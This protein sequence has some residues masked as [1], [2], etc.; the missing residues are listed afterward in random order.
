MGSRNREGGGFLFW[1]YLRE[2]K[3][4]SDFNLS[5]KYVLEF[6]VKSSL[7]GSRKEEGGGLPV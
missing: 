3:V 5:P 1:L 2:P 7:G 4:L 6:S